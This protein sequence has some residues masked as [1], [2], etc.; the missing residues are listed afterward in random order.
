MEKSCGFRARLPQ[1]RATEA[2]APNS[3]NG[4]NIKFSHVSLPPARNRNFASVE[5]I[6]QTQIPYAH[7]KQINQALLYRR[8]SEYCLQFGLTLLETHNYKHVTKY[9]Q[10]GYLAQQPLHTYIAMLLYSLTYI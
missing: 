8:E 3:P 10:R 7:S 1:P 2:L 6:A 9:I 4:G 5:Q